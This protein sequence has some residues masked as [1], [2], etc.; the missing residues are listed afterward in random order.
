[1]KDVG[2][3]FQLQIKEH[4]ML[5]TL[6]SRKVVRTSG[7]KIDTHPISMSLLASGLSKYV[8]DLPNT[9]LGSTL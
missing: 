6:G 4:T 5:K 8:D 7:V 2:F 3:L 1:M 9:I